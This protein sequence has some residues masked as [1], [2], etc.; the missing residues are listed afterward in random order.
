MLTVTYAACH[1]KAHMLSI[2]MLNVVV[3]SAMVPFLV[4]DKMA[5]WKNG[6]LTERQRTIFSCRL[7]TLNMS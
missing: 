5:N 7:F 6:E 2:V 3:L 1:F 4:V